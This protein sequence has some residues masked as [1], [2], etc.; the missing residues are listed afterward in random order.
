VSMQLPKPSIKNELHNSNLEKAVLGA[1]LL[2][3]DDCATMVDMLSPE[4][5]G[6]HRHAVIFR[7]VKSLYDQEKP[8]DYT[9]VCDHL[10]AHEILDKVGG[11]VYLSDLMSE[12][13][14]DI[15]GYCQ[16]ILEYQTRRD[17]LSLSNTLQ[18]IATSDQ[19]V[20]EIVADIQ[21]EAMKLGVSHRDRS[22][23]IDDYIH[24]WLDRLEARYK[25]GGRVTGVQTGF[26]DLDRMT[27]GLQPSD[28]VIV[29]ARPGMGKSA[30]VHN[31]MLAAA[32]R[33]DT[34]S[35]L[36][37]L[38]MS[39]ESVVTRMV[40]TLSG[41]PVESL[42]SGY[43]REDGWMQVTDAASKLYQHGIVI[44][45]TPAITV[46]HL[47]Q[48]ARRAQRQHNIGFIAV[49]YL[50]L[51]KAEAE[52]RRVEV[53]EVSRGLKAVAKELNLPVVAVS[54]L[55][56]AVETRTNKEPM[57]SDLRESGGIEQDADVVVFL[58]RD[59]YY[60]PESDQKGSCK[61]NIA[62][63]RNGKTGP[64]YLH[65]LPETCTFHSVERGGE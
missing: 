19:D 24:G 30:W 50:Q 2:R 45:D 14:T 8:V 51:M 37:S 53:D 56:R 47:R 15:E 11:A 28:L 9:T 6:I 42:R 12:I 17:I 62:K 46:A 40:S 48:V 57:L 23:I 13:C 25:A 39:A 16:K 33:Y 1:A 10:E 3:H 31:I 61:V 18:Q 54:Q 7:A 38:E 22:V 60:N 64:F 27:L 34:P 21:G 63:Q 29:A 58:Y 26:H 52:S 4:S 59:E 65:W 41:V 32:L 35:I 20:D 44:D 43:I 55:S 36:F 49:D 5:F